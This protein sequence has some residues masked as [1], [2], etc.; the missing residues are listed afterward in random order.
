MSWNS[1][2]VLFGALGVTLP[3]G[4]RWLGNS[5][6]LTYI[7]QLA[8]AIL[9]QPKLLY[10]LNYFQSFTALHIANEDHFLCFS[11]CFPKKILV[12]LFIYETESCYIEQ[13][14]CLRLLGSRLFCV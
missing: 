7:F 9:S 8:T 14:S 11:N 4:R 12:Y 1:A 10:Y 6:R 2:N 13:S 3:E 5:Y